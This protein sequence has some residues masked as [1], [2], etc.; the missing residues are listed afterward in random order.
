MDCEAGEE[1]SAVAAD[2]V[3]QDPDQNFR[4]QHYRR[5]CQFVVSIITFLGL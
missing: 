5:K 4:C 1:V 2:G 3:S